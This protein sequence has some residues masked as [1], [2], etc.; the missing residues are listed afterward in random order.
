MV[1]NVACRWPMH[2]VFL[3]YCCAVR[4]VCLSSNLL[5]DRLDR[6]RLLSNLLVDR[7]RSFGH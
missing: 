3:T 5:L 7:S 1:S 6:A 2:G 4:V